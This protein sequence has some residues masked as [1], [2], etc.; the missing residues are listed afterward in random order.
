[1]ENERRSR[2][3][4]GRLAGRYLEDNGEPRRMFRKKGGGDM[5]RLLFLAVLGLWCFGTGLL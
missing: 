3:T 2:V 5:V 4:P 1:M